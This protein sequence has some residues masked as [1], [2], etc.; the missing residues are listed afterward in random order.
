MRTA[1]PRRC[2]RSF[3]HCSRFVVSDRQTSLS[4]RPPADHRSRWLGQLP[5]LISAARLLAG[6]LLI[7]LALAHAESGFRWLLI[8]ALLSDIADGWVA[9]A[10]GLQSKL[11]AL[12]DSAADVVTLVSASVGIAVFHPEVFRDHRAGCAI[13]LGGWFA[14][15]VFA[16]LRYRRLSSFHTYASKAAGYALGLFLG[17]LFLTGFV[18]ALFYPA[19]VLSV[20]ASAE[21][22]MLLW[23]LPQ[24][25]SD[26]RGIWW[27]RRERFPAESQRSA[28]GSPTQPD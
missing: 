19:V 23:Y 3:A 18:A 25:R 2:R 14:V 11:G 28:N 4:P 12:L 26:V 27:V 9:R 10:F 22:L 17:G 8:T 6:P 24:W 13:V 1:A 16:L 21:E 20:I 15:S 5:N 7:G